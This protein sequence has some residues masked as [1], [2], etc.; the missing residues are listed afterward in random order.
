MQIRQI[1]KD[2]SIKY[3]T[4]KLSD[5]PEDIQ[6]YESGITIDHPEYGAGYKVYTG[7][8]KEGNT[9]E[10]ISNKK[11]QGSNGESL[12]SYYQIA[13]DLNQFDLNSKSY[14]GVKEIDGKYYF[15]EKQLNL[16]ENQDGTFGSDTRPYSTM[17]QITNAK[18]LSEA[19][20]KIHSSTAEFS[21]DAN[22]NIEIGSTVGFQD[23]L[24][25]VYGYNN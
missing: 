3:D 17:K 22:G 12:E 5:L 16:N 25:E 9:F 8:D 10:I 15:L 14:T 23:H 7:V 18:S 6:F 4:N 13:N 21:T 20:E 19:K 24:R 2:G 11:Q 1:G